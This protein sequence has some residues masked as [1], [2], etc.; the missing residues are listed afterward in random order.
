MSRF[1]RFFSLIVL[2]SLLSLALAACG[3]EASSDVPPYTGAQPITLDQQTQDSFNASVKGIKDAKLQAYSISGDSAQIQAYYESQ[4]KDKGWTSRDS[5][6]EEEAR[7][8]QLQN[9]WA[10]AYEKGNKVV[11]LIFTPA[12]SAS[13]HFPQA[14]G[15]NVLLVVSASK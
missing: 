6:I 4:Y 1:F 3:S 15:N 2:L 8:Q 14:Q 5:Q 11:S 7:Q 9:G 10:M 13:I 12:S